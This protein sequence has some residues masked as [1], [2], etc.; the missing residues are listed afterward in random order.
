VSRFTSL[1]K[2]LTVWKLTANACLDHTTA[3]YFSSASATTA[4][5][6]TSIIGKMLTAPLDE[7]RWDRSRF[8]KT[9]IGVLFYCF[10]F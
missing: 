5:P 10:Y 2:K 8:T 1:P 3:I 4:I 9:A 7:E 6:M